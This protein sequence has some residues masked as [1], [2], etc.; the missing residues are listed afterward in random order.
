LFI[1]VLNGFSFSHSW[2]LSLWAGIYFLNDCSRIC[3]L[4][5][6]AEQLTMLPILDSYCLIGSCMIFRVTCQPFDLKEIEEAQ[7]FDQQVYRYFTVLGICRL[8]SNSCFRRCNKNSYTRRNSWFSMSLTTAFR[9]VI[10]FFIRLFHVLTS[11]SCPPYSICWKSN[12]KPVLHIF[13]PFMMDSYRHV[14]INN[15]TT[16]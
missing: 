7:L 12:L 16:A 11:K 15:N 3:L 2:P 9:S 8:K 10:L 5:K 13:F 4:N 6:S 14:Q 1:I